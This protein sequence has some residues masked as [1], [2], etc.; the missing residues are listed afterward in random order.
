VGWLYD[1]TAETNYERVRDLARYPEL[2]VLNKLWWIPPTLLGFGVWFWLGWSGLWI[3]FC[4]STVIL[5]HATFT[6][7]SFT[8][9][10]GR[11]RFQTTDESRN[12]LFFALLTLG[13][14]W[15]NNHHHYQAC[16]RQGFYWWEID[17]TYYVIRLLAAVGLVWDVREPPARVYE[18]AEAAKLQRAA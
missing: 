5:W 9:L 18:E 8:H 4:A 16:T 6:I 14:G 17:I 12:S 13:E 15:H 11:K 3:A 2:V 1:H 7:N 10:W